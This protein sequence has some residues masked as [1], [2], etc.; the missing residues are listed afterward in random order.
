[1]GLFSNCIHL[2]DFTLDDCDFVS[3]LQ[4]II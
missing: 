1:L 2:A 4:I 3:D